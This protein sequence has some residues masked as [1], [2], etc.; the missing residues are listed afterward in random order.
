MTA[1]RH[2][3][4]PCCWPQ[5]PRWPPLRAGAGRLADQ[6]GDHR[7]ALPARR[8]HRRLRA[9][10][11]RA[12]EQ[13]HSASQ[14][15]IDNKGGAGGTLGAGIAAR[16]APDGYTF[17]MGAVHHAIAP[18]MYPKLDYNIETDFVPVGLV[19]SVPQVIVVNPQRVPATDLQELLELP[20]QEPGQAELRLGRQRHLA[21]PGRRAVQAADQDLHHPHPLPRRR[22]GAAGP[23]RRPGGHDVRRPGLV[24]HAHQGRPH[25][26]AGRGRRQARAGLPRRAHRRRGAA[27]RPTRSPPGTACGRPRARRKD[28]VDAHAGRDA[29]ALNSDELKA[30]WTGLGTDTP[31]LCGDAFGQLRRRRDQAL[32]RG[33]EGLGREAGV[34]SAATV[35]AHSRARR[36]PACARVTLANPGKHE[37]ASSMAMWQRAARARSRPAALPRTRRAW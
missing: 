32:G 3:P 15:V 1:A 27:C 29:K 21:P 8:R 25:Q 36:G 23:D 22:P 20:A 19:S 34:M 31:N 37:R 18:R 14:F 26:G 7:R 4:Q 35:Q 17:F 5:P 13:E 2:P 16:A 30:T 6:A 10:A 11:V 28:V 12:D 9:A 33:G 24:G